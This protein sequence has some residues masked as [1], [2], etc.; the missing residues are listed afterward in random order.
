MG[1]DVFPLAADL[2]AARS[3][4]AFTL[5]FHIVLASI[6]VGFP[7]IILDRE[8]LGLRRGD[9]R[10]AWPRAALVEGGG[11]HLRGRRDHRDRALVRDGSA[12]AGVH[13]PLRRRL[14]ARLRARG[15]LLL[16]RGDLHRDLHLRLEAPV[17]VGA[18]LDRRPGRDRR[19]RRRLV[20]GRGEL[21]DEPARRLQARLR[22]DRDRR[23]ARWTRSSTARS[24]TRPRT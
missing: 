14:R 6:G 2:G 4:M 17:G 24:P 5:G 3:Q 9:E 8:L 16:H 18:L 7:A 11:R 1:A 10:R 19:P 12:V 21:V 20:R 23:R 15:D 22:R 13:A